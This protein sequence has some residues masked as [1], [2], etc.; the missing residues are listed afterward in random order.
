[1]EIQRV[2][3]E[4]AAHRIFG[5]VAEHV[6]VKETPMLVRGIV[7]G[8]SAAKGR[9][10][11]GFRPDQYVYQ[12]KPAADDESAAKERLDLL[13]CR[14]GGDIEILR[15]DSEQQVAHRA[16]HDEGLEACLLQL[17]RYF[18]RPTRNRGPADRVRIGTI[19]TRLDCGHAREQAREEAADHNGY[20]RRCCKKGAIL[21]DARIIGAGDLRGFGTGR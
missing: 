19:N 10:L 5:L 11:D 9:H 12:T 14:V 13:G 21:T 8:L 3:R 18:E 2:D 17:A 6:V 16:A 1:V 4:V 15:L 20:L 7:A